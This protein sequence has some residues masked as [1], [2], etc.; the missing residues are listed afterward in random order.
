MTIAETMLEALRKAGPDGITLQKLLT[1]SPL[2][3]LDVINGLATL[4]FEG[5]ATVKFSAWEQTWKAVP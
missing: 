5:R 1:D 3:K 2:E 4:R